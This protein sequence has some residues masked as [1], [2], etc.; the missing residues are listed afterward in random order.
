[1]N[2]WRPAN[3]RALLYVHAASAESLAEHFTAVSLLCIVVVW[4]LL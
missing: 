3:T 1:M 4:S 2:A